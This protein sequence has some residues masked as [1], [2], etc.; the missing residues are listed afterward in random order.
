[1]YSFY[2]STY[3]AIISSDLEPVFISKTTKP[4]Q[5]KTFLSDQKRIQTNE[6]AQSNNVR[7]K[8][9]KNA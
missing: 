7:F 1:M 9:T 8:N 4:K 6:S 3:P 2:H 5:R